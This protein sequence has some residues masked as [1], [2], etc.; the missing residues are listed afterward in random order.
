MT[1][2]IERRFVAA[3]MEL[4]T[5][6]N[7][8]VLEGYAAVFGKRSQNL[9]GFVEQV[10]PGAFTKTLKDGADVRALLNHDPNFVL[11]RSTSGTLRMAQDDTGLHYEVDLGEQSYARDLAISLERGDITQSSFG[12]R[13]ISDEWGFS[14]DDFPLRT[15][16]EVALGDVSPVTYPAYLDATSG[17]GQRALDRLAETRGMAAGEITPAGLLTVLR[18][19]PAAPETPA[20]PDSSTLRS[21]LRSAVPLDPKAAMF[22]LTSR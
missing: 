3:Q 13:T 14:E 12:F 10:N 19:A 4:R 8:A 1:S 6:G 18:G 20:E 2:T 5:V 17:L 11:G 9:G 22:Y 21:T 15:L 16:R 7:K